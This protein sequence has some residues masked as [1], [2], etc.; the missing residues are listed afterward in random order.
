MYEVQKSN[1]EQGNP[2]IKSGQFG[3]SNDIQET[4]ISRMIRLM[5]KYYIPPKFDFATYQKTPF[6]M[7][8]FEF[9]H[10]FD[11]QDLADIWQ[12]V[13]P[14]IG[15]QA[16]HSDNEDDNEIVHELGSYDFFEGSKIPGKV[17]WLVLKVKQ[18]GEKNYYNITADSKD[19]DRFKFD[20]QVGK[21]AP[22][23]SYNWP[24]D[25]FS[26]VELVNVEGGVIIEGGRKE[27]KSYEVADISASNTEE[28]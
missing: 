26:L 2:A 11:Q 23:Y 20:F 7:Y 22:E 3:A 8:I 17:R 10:T 6:I 16:R 18:K 14:K 13:M 12:G 24:Y 28:E 19:D 9:N 1:V 5:K 27:T 25:F 4:S 15:H 21:Q